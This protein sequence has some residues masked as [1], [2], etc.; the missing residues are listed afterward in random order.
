MNASKTKTMVTKGCVPIIQQST[1]AYICCLTG[2]GS[3]YWEH[4]MDIVQC[5]L[6]PTLVQQCSYRNHVRFCHFDVY[7][8]S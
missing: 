7:T 8:T 1:M 2:Q 5:P 3:S 4:E 6:C